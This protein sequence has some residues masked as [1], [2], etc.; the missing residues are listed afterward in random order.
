MISEFSKKILLLVIL[1]VVNHRE[2]ALPSDA[3]INAHKP[4][5]YSEYV[6]FDT[7][8]YDRISARQNY[9]AQ[10]LDEQSKTRMW[11]VVGLSTAALLGVCGGVYWFCREPEKDPVSQP[12]RVRLSAEDVRD[13][14]YE[15]R[16]AL[17][18]KS[19]TAR[20]MVESGLRDGLGYAVSSMAVIMT[21]GFLDKVGLISLKN[22]KSF[23]YP[24]V[25]DLCEQQEEMFKRYFAYLKA[26]MQDLEHE[27]NQV[28]TESQFEDFMKWRGLFSAD[29]QTSVTSVVRS[30]EEFSAL[31]LEFITRKTRDADKENLPMQQLKEF[32]L[33]IDQLVHTVNNFSR[34]VE[35]LVNEFE[36]SLLERDRVQ[37]A[38]IFKNVLQSARGTMKKFMDLV[39][40]L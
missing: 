31:S 17:I 3:P 14:Y 1:I 21:M 2:I 11:T 20:G 23:F 33:S 4:V 27:F 10:L 7:V 24:T 18:E 40:I 37:A 22:I 29:A 6:T 19:Q 16:L 36:F 28:R 5:D 38:M 32:A 15:R 8:S 30:V 9:I 12:A 35:F 13:R 34:T 39:E 25:F 26:A